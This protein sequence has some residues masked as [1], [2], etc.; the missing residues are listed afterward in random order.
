M[1]YIYDQDGVVG[2]LGNTSVISMFADVAN[3]HNMTT[4]RRFLKNG[5][6]IEVDRL[7][8][9]IESVDYGAT[10][11]ADIVEEIVGDL[12]KCKGMVILNAGVE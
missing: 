8:G 1:Y 9:E 6:T 7:I 5:F 11:L 2:D 3:E 4:L 10:E 12:R